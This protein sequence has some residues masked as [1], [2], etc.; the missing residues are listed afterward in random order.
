MT[1]AA[2][3]SRRRSAAIAFVLG[4]AVAAVG[5]VLPPAPLAYRRAWGLALVASLLWFVA[6]YVFFEH[7]AGPG[8]VAHLGLAFLAIVGLMAPRHLARLETGLRNLARI[9]RA[10]KP[11]IAE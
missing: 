4:A 5:I 7:F 9:S 2:R 1:T 8:F 3:T 11:P 6:L 10:A